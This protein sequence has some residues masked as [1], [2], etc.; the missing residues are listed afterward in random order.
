MYVEPGDAVE[1][2]AAATA[3][4]LFHIAGTG[5][6][7]NIRDCP[8]ATTWHRPLPTG[9]RQSRPA[10]GSPPRRAES[11][12]AEATGAALL[13]GC[14]TGGHLWSRSVSGVPIPWFR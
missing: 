8:R 3:R 10:I 12:A 1:H 2:V 14:R 4:P 11:V 13:P 6:G 9:L 5:G 7:L